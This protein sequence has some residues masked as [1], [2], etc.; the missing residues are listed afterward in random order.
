MSELLFV[1][2]SAALANNIVLHQ[3]LA[4]DPAIREDG[5]RV[6]A[7]GLA[8]LLLMVLAVGAGQALV[9]Y[10][11]RPFQLDYLRLFVFLP[12][13]VLLVDPVTGLLQRQLP[14]GSFTGLK[15]LL[16]GNTALLGLSLQVS[17]AALSGL[18]TLALTLGSGLGF[19]LVMYL[20][21]NL[22]QRTDSTG[23]PAAFRGLPITLIGA[24]IMALAFLGFNGLFRP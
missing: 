14:D 4:I 23:V 21:D 19:W 24:G 20:L 22:R 12:L 11:L 17:D 9:N 5:K 10:G 8:T 7:L 18:Q 6:H 3:A 16:L 13:C 15:P 1:L 2:F